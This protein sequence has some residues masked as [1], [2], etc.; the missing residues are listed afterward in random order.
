M[1]N[2]Y[3]PSSDDSDD[4]LGLQSL[5]LCYQTYEHTEKL[6]YFRL[7]HHIGALRDTF[8]VSFLF[9][10]PVKETNLLSSTTQT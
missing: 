8:F 6:R 1:Y 5:E 3:T 9:Y 10:K 7:M 4:L 2:I